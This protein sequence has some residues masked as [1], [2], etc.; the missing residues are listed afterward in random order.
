M[1]LKLVRS[2]LKPNYIIGHLYVNDAFFCDVL[3]LPLT[4]EGK[5]NVRGK[6]CIPYGKYDI[7][8]D[9]YSPRFG[10][11]TFYRE[12]CKGKLPRLENVP[13]RDGI[14]I[15][16]G[17]YPKD[18]NGCLLVGQNR[19]VGKVINSKDTFRKLARVMLGAVAS[20]D[21]ITIEII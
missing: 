20:Y 7:R 2:A 15:H 9:V 10:G 12:T 8:M 3:E 11:E 19:E 14:L 13:G 16:A 1:R 5:R 21:P 17:N 6:T 4:Y 18:T